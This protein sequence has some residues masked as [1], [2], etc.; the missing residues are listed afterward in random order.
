[1]GTRATVDRG[2][3]DYLKTDLFNGIGHF[4]TSRLV[5]RDDRKAPIV[6]KN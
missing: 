2:L 4:E 5:V 1:M 3:S 6:L